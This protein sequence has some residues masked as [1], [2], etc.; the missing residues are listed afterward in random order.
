MPP[1]SVV[2]KDI[3]ADIRQVVTFLDVDL[4]FLLKDVLAR[5]SKQLE[6]TPFCW[7]MLTHT[8]SGSLD[9]VHQTRCYVTFTSRQF[10]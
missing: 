7:Q 6:P 10:L 4:G 1:A 2:P 3:T 8:S 5:Y 9:N